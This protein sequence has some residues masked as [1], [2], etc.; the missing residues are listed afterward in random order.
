VHNLNPRQAICLLLTFHQSFPAPRV[1]LFTLLSFLPPSLPPSLHPNSPTNAP[2]NPPKPSCTNLKRNKKRSNEKPTA[3]WASSPPMVLMKL[4]NFFGSLLNG[5]RP[6][7]IDRPC[8][9]CCLWGFARWVG[10]KACWSIFCRYEGEG[11]EGGRL[12]ER[13]ELLLFNSISDRHSPIPPPHPP[14]PPPPDPHAFPD[15]HGAG[16]FHGIDGL[17]LLPL[18]LHPLL[19]P[20]FPYGA[21]FLLWGC[22]CCNVHGSHLLDPTVRHSGCDGV[23]GCEGLVEQC[24][25]AGTGWG[26]RK[27]WTAA[28]PASRVGRVWSRGCRD[29]KRRSENKKEKT[30]H[31]KS[32]RGR[33]C[34]LL[35]LF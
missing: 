1:L 3:T 16:P 5:G 11:R 4:S 14:Q 18:V 6:L 26:G 10:M 21:L 13:K 33:T 9:T 22:H 27:G 2:G 32:E 34:F 31:R 25:S 20:R 23:C 12:P 35:V 29:K 19:F 8:S 28:K 30:G 7:D 24:E 15:Q 17:H